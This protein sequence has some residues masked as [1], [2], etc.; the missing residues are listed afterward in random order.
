ML[1]LPDE[2]LDG[3]PKRSI[4]DTFDF[5]GVVEGDGEVYRELEL[6]YLMTI[7]DAGRSSPVDSAEFEVRLREVDRDPESAARV[8]SPEELE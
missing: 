1:R 4:L 5:L 8:A 2:S 7:L 6:D 3:S